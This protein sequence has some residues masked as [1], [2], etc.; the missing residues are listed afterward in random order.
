MRSSRDDFTKETLST[1]A[2][3]VGYA[4]TV[5]CKSVRFPS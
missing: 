2:G 3:R 4:T 1:A 5:M